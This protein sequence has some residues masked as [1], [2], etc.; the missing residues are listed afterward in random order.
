MNDTTEAAPSAHT[1]SR[2][3][4]LLLYAASLLVDFPQDAKI[5]EQGGSAGE[6]GLLRLTVRREDIGKVIGKQ[7]RTARALRNLVTATA[8]L[9]GKRV[10][11]SVGDAPGPAQ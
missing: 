6:G 7:G 4:E 1:D 10:A 2:L 11:V 3:H 8:Q 9:H 5:V